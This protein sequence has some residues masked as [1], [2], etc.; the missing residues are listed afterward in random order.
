MKNLYVITGTVFSYITII[1]TM[2]P[3]YP[4]ILG[5]YNYLNTIHDLYMATGDIFF[6]NVL[7]AY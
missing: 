6:L 4:K 5:M 7:T 3:C 2:R 1:K